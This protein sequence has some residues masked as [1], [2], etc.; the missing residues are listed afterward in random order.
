M[1][2]PSC[3]FDGLEL[4]TRG[5]TYRYRGRATVVPDVTGHVCTHCDEMVL[6][7]AESRRVN[8]QMRAFNADVNAEGRVDPS[9]I[10][11]VRR[12]LALGQREASVLFGGG[13]NAFSRYETGKTRP[14]LALVQ[15][16]RLLD[17]HPELLRELRVTS[18]AASAHVH[19]TRV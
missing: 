8:A 7:V 4:R 13:T 15:L 18:T 12:K 5:V 6:S 16:L 9:Y 19:G 10:S 11:T 17:R 1:L 14:P 3:G 2:C